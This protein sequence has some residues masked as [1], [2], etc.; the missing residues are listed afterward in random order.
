M[1]R[2]P[3][4]DENGLKKGAWSPDEDEKLKAYVHK[5]GHCN[6]RELPRFAGLSRCGK[7][8]RLRWINYLCPDV[9]R[10]NYSKEEER[11]ILQLHQEHG[12][13]WSLMATKLPGR[14]DNEIKNYWHTHLKKVK[15]SKV[16]K[17]QQNE[18]ISMK[19]RETEMKANLISEVPSHEILE[20]SPFSPLSSEIS[21]VCSNQ[22]ST[23]DSP[24]TTFKFQETSNNNNGDFWDVPFLV[25]NLEAQSQDPMFFH[26]NYDFE[27]DQADLFYQV[28][29]E[30][31]ENYQPYLYP[32]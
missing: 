7:S 5:H 26:I 20:S 9:K 15:A 28:M 22:E 8:C 14:T 21:T 11:L 27:F 16:K 18:A 6:W 23:Q 29:K 2:A 4:F 10:G 31:P 24:P 17:K 25:D 1:V 32:S 30:L 19:E 3:Y 13:K 12:N